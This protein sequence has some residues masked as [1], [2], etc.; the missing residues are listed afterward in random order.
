M[1][2]LHEPLLLSQFVL[3]NAGLDQFC[4]SMRG[5]QM[6]EPWRTGWMTPE[7]ISVSNLS[8]EDDCKIPL[9]AYA[10]GLGTFIKEGRA[11]N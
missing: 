8:Q 7:D 6:V 4:T 11:A 3:R 10:F 5:G 2:R 9:E 1:S